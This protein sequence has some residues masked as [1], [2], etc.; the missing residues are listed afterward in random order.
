[1]PNHRQAGGEKVS[2]RFRQGVVQC[3]LDMVDRKLEMLEVARRDQRIHAQRL[4]VFDGCDQQL[5]FLVDV[6]GL[7]PGFWIL[8]RIGFLFW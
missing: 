8:R 3:F 6:D 7:A 2:L 1:M 5:R 4:R